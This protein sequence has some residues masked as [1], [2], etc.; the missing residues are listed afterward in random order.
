MGALISGLLVVFATITGVMAYNVGK[1]GGMR[2]KLSKLYITLAISSSVW[3]FCFGAI[4]VQDNTDTAYILRCIG[5]VGTFACLISAVFLIAEW[6]G[7]GKVAS[8]S[9]KM[10]SLLGIVIYPFN[11][12]REYIEFKPAKVGMSY[13]FKPDFWTDAYMVYSTIIAVCLFAI[14]FY[15]IRST[16]KRRIK[17]MG[18]LL[19]GSLTIITLG[20][21]F[22][23]I[24]PSF[25]ITAVPTSSLGQA[26]CVFMVYTSLNVK[27][28]NRIDRSNI[29]SYIDN[30][31]EV[32]MLVCDED[33]R[34]RLASQS[35]IKFMS[36]KS[37]EK[38]TIGDLFD[39]DEKCYR[40]S[41]ESARYDAVCTRN[42]I[43]CNL[44]LELIKDDFNDFIGYIV[45]VTDMTEKMAYI[46]EIEEAKRSADRA[47]A[48]KSSFLASM[49]H[50]IRT[51]LNAVLGIDEM[52]LRESDV[53]EIH[54][55][56][57]SIM[58]AGKSLLAIIDDILDFSK[59]ESGKM[60]I[61]DVDYD[62]S[63]AVR[64]LY[65]IVSYRAKKKGLDLIFD[66]D[67]NI[68]KRLRGDELRVR[69]ILIN[70]INNAVKYTNLGWVKVSAS[71]EWINSERI[72]LVVSVEDT[73]IG[74][75]KE[76]LPTLFE[77]FKRL[78]EN[79]NYKVEGTGLGLSIV[80]GLLEMMG[81]NVEVKSVYQR[82]S[83]FI[84]RI[85]QIVVDKEPIGVF[86]M[87]YSKERKEYKESFKAPRARILVVDD[88]QINLRIVEGLLKQTSIQIDKKTNGY[89]CLEAVKNN[90]YD[91][92]LL[93]YMMSQMDG[94]EVLNRLK[95]M[96]NNMSK[97]AHVI[98]LTANAVVGAKEEYIGH[99]FDDYLA[100][101]IDV[102]ELECVIR[103]HLPEDLIEPQD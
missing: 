38:Y 67:T 19:L 10:F 102:K 32:Y 96:E 83:K 45:S 65:S 29:A 100:K 37:D 77:K 41:D 94:M 6:S 51:P 64:E 75:R 55:L 16:K 61:I 69:Q 31:T 101:P 68:P 79:V 66:I 84:V 9:V 78:D 24:L 36:L 34:I 11:I 20:M 92:I 46:S 25:G 33:F 30:S 23:T 59:I 50:E 99:G 62:Y 43:K 76:E 49:S 2:Q 82:G 28:K 89:D 103:T 35:A 81:G 39:L 85:P 26:L 86:N 3:S 54:K 15:M 47:N 70:I 1:N 14:V 7:I 40:I 90:K 44:G 63:Q 18:R 93:D 97:E 60:S 17:V 4:L 42:G 72:E 87:E 48:S 12:R 91:L 95:A 74:I 71:C 21:L 98:A 57:G 27:K 22:D 13:S 58:D 5:M 73:G 53:E 88:N 56:A 80:Y 52:I 8:I